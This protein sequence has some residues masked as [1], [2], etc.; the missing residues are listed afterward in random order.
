[1]AISKKIESFM[2]NASWIR[3]MFEDGIRMKKE[4]GA[5]NVFDFSLGNP[6]MEPPQAFKNILKDAILE[7]DPGQH[8]Y[9][10]NAG[11]PEVR[12]K[13]AE[14]L[15][16]QTNSDLEQD[17]IIMTCGAGGALNVALKSLLNPEEE[18]IVIA[19]YFPEY[20]F[21]VDNHGGKL[22]T[23][24]S[25]STFDLDI[26]N[27]EKAITPKTKAI[28]LNSPNNPTGRI[29]SAELL[30]ELGQLL[31][32]KEKDTSQAIT[33]LS[34]EPYRKIVF[35]GTKVP[36]IFDAHPNTILI[37]SHSKDLGLPGERIGYAA[38]S[39]RHQDRNSLRAAMT[40]TNRTLGFVNAPALFQRTVAL[41]QDI[42]VPIADY[43]KLRDIFHQGLFQAGMECFLPGGA[44]YLF[45]KTPIEDDVAFVRALQKQHILAVPGSGFGRPGHIR[46]CFCVTQ[47]EIENS[48]PGFEKTMA[49][50]R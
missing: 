38:I 46:L 6:I 5:E 43:Q 18:V 2:T 35:D 44:F 12:A 21:Y 33:I 31:A 40:F 24:E 9:M 50:Y 26:A 34:D 45:P 4:V 8:R 10:P 17:D 39:P 15:N 42:S 47:Q 19:P 11:Y 37:T 27:I 7:P 30:K 1:V 20:Q 22:V 29:Y 36:A 14:Y 28:I 3:K 13:I 48:L 41:A 25:T 49:E 23:V 32:K 16:K